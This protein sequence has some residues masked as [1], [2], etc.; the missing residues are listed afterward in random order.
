MPKTG[1]PKWPEFQYQ[2]TCSPSN[3]VKSL[4]SSPGATCKQHL[5]AS[6]EAT[7]S[8]A[9]ISPETPSRY[10]CNR[11]HFNP[12]QSPTALNNQILQ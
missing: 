8:Q 2:R 10:S 9:K 7:K 5:T 1:S 3:S 4:K 11:T 12:Y 6:S